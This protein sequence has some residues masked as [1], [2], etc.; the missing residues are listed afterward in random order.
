M[1]EP[2]PA[3]RDRYPCPGCSTGYLDCAQ[4]WTMSLQCCADCSHPG[5]AEA[6]P[7]FTDAEVNDM[8][9]RTGMP[10][11]DRRVEVTLLG[12]ELEIVERSTVDLPLPEALRR[13]LMRKLSAVMEEAATRP[14]WAAGYTVAE[15]QHQ[16]GGTYRR[17]R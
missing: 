6:D 7:P 12:F 1:A 2:K 9:R 14:G 10:S 5:H 11:V 15:Y 3:Y 13:P 16:G 8:R 17:V 4:F